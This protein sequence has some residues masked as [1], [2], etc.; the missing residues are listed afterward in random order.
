MS[1][2]ITIG[3][4]TPRVQ[5]VASGTQTIFTFRFPVFDPIDLEIRI[6]GTVMSGGFT[7]ANAGQSTGGSVTFDDPPRAGA[8]VTIRRNLKIMRITDFQDN[9]ILRARTLN[10]E[11]DYQVAALQQVRDEVRR[12]VQLAVD[13]FSDPG[14]LPSA[15]AGQLLGFDA[16][17]RLSAYPVFTPT[18]LPEAGQLNA[19]DFGA[20]GDGI[21]DD[22]EALRAACATAAFQGRVLEI[23][24]GTYRTTGTVTLP[25]AAAGLLMRGVICSEGGGYPALVLGDGGAVRNGEKSYT[26]LRVLRAA[27]SDWSDETDIG[28]VVRNLDESQVEIR[29]AEGYT[30][31]VRTLGEGRGVQNSTFF[32]G[33]LVNNKIGLD[34]NTGTAQGWNNAVRYYGGHFAAA[35]YINRGME[36]FGVRFSAAPG[37]YVLHNG[38]VFDGPNFE[39]Q[40]DATT[41]GIPFLIEVNSR[42]VQ[43]RGIRME[44][45]S[46][47]VARHTA[48][49]QDH[50]YDV[51]WASQ[52]YMLDIDYTSTATRVGSIVR[53]QHQNG[54][55]AECNRVVA[56][57]PCLRGAAVRW[58]NTETGF[59]G[60]ACLS[61][62]VANGA[63]LSD[64]A[65]PALTGM[66]LTSRGVMLSAARGIGF[67]VDV[68][69]CRELALAVD[70]DPTRLI[71]QCFDEAGKLMGSSG[72]TLVRGSSQSFTWNAT[73]RWYQSVADMTDANWTRRPAVRIDPSVATV[74]IGVARGDADA[75]IRALRLFSSATGAPATL[76]GSDLIL[77]GRNEFIGEAYWDPPSIVAGGTAQ[78]SVPL[79][80]ARPGDFVQVGFS[81]ATSGVLF[82]AQVGAMDI[83]SVTAWNR[84]GAALDLGPGTV[85]VRLVKV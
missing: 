21:A 26:G 7:V 84:T 81:I 59:L 83:V 50:V 61:T 70:G 3:D 2:H 28:I 17:G 54:G 4:V 80:G 57:I 63:S 67:A 38:H 52:G 44:A 15:R 16:A 82:L 76:H 35:S 55:H 42:G 69:N 20:V 1:S 5:Y 33:R 40:A 36:R 18:P 39:L 53:V 43:A 47:Y 27:Q 56:A 24:E 37:A 60:L 65:F 51:V 45:C 75:E 9:G 30:I 8:Q 79:A 71:V 48:G 85:R 74:I 78:L 66:A 46:P 14:T 62:S 32:F 10:D 19:R 29:Q 22:T 49:A 25:G 12:T 6:D 77:A 64:F 73:A 31:G 41:T 23:P 11:L 58:S 34:V 72:A 68:R 13:D